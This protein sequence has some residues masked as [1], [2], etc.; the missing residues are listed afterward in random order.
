M[1]I[2]PVVAELFHA[3]ER[4]D[5]DTHADMMWLI[6]AL[7]NLANA[8][9]IIPVSA[10]TKKPDSHYRDRHVTGTGLSVPTQ[11]AAHHAPVISVCPVNAQ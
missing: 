2:C 6:V 4:T 8:S 11:Y 9:N 10:Q 3:D 1:K 7:L 5:T